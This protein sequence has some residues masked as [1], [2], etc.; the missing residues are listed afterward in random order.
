MSS[1][2]ESIMVGLTEAVEDAKA[3]KRHYKDAR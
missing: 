3:E 1:V 2:Y